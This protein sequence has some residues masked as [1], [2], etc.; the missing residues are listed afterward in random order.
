MISSCLFLNLSTLER[1]R[2]SNSDEK[3]WNIS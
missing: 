3:G 1:S 2:A